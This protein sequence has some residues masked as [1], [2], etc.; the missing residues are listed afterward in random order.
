MNYKKKKKRYTIYLSQSVAEIIE[1]L[2][3][4]YRDR[5]RINPTGGAF[6]RSLEDMII[7]CVEHHPWYLR[8]LAR[9]GELQKYLKLTMLDIEKKKKN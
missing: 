3:P 4:L 7:Q 5:N 8:K 1:A 2:A 6:T 9:L